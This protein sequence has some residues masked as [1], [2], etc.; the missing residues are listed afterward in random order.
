M[1]TKTELIKLV[2]GY[3]S[4]AITAEYDVTTN[5]AT[6]DTGNHGMLEVTPTESGY[7]IVETAQD[8]Y[9][10]YWPSQPAVASKN[11]K[12]VKRWLRDSEPKTYKPN[13]TLVWV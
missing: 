1:K 2:N 11:L 13:W 10:D 12:G 7:S 3:K 9:G 5:K 6:F 8:P 4:D